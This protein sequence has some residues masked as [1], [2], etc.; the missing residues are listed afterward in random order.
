MSEFENNSL[1]KNKKKWKKPLLT[2]MSLSK[3]KAT[4]GTGE[5]GSV[6]TS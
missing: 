5:D 3:T 2:V 4:N 1:Q 6:M